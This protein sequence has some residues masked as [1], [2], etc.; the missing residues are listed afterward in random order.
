MEK[1]VGVQP[2]L[3][4]AQVSRRKFL[5]AGL[6]A[7]SGLIAMALGIPV[8]GYAVSPAFAKKEQSWVQLGSVGEFKPLQPTKVDY[9]VFRRD[10]WIE[11][12]VKKSAWIVLPQGGGEAVVFDPRCT[13]LGCAYR[14]D[15]G[16]GKF[17]CP[18]HDARFD[19]DGKVVGGPP[20]RPL[21]RLKTKVEG[22]KIFVM[23]G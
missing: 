17:L 11:E 14:W 8:A 9:D 2:Q 10:G 12:Q 22:G 19:I 21:D 20:P 18:C 7:I 1:G 23:E 13:H 3:Q 6:G 16:E 15:Q 4:D 5:T